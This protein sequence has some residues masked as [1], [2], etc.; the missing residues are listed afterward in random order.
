MFSSSS[1]PAPAYT[2]QLICSSSARKFTPASV[3]LIH[4]NA[5]GVVTNEIMK[6][7]PRATNSTSGISIHATD[8]SPEMVEVCLARVRKSGCADTVKC[9]SHGDV[10]SYF[11]RRHV[12]ALLHKVR[13]L[14]SPRRRR[15]SS[16]FTHL[17]HTEAR[18]NHSHHCLGSD[19]A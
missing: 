12:H 4:D 9:L 3:R 11:P 13:K 8:P 14:L 19:A 15:R 10:R 1:T 18:R 6:V 2:S 5:C 16:S 7:I 17:P